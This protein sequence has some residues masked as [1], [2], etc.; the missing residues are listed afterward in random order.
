VDAKKFVRSFDQGC[1]VIV[2]AFNGKDTV[3]VIFVWFIVVITQSY[4]II[5][6][7]FPTSVEYDKFCF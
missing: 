4:I 7:N 1:M 3:W 2:E 6:D 5:N